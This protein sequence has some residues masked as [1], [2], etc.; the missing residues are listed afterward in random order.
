MDD[1]RLCVDVGTT[2]TRAWLTQGT[3]VLVRR[4][5]PVGARDT[6][7]DG[8]AGTLARALRDVLADVQ[9][10]SPRP[11]PAGSWLPAC[12]PL[13]RG[14]REVPHV[15]AP[16]GLAEL[17]AA[18]HEE[19]LSEVSELPFLFVPGVRTSTRPGADGI[20]GRDVMRGEETLSLGLAPLGLL[21]PG[22]GLLSLGSHWKLI[23][24]DLE[25]R[26]AFSITSIAGSCCRPS[27]SRRSSR[28]R[29]LTGRSRRQTRPRCG[30]ECARRGAT[31]SRAPSSACACWSW[32]RRR[33]RAE[34][35]A[36]ALGAFVGADFD[37]LEAALGT[38]TP[39]TIAG[40]EKTGG[41]WAQALEEAGHPVAFADGRGGGGGPAGRP[42]RDRRR[43][44]RHGMTATRPILKWAGGKQALAARLVE[45]FPADY[46][47][48]FEP[49]VGGASVFLALGPARAVLCDRNR[50][51]IE[52]YE[53]VR[54]DAPRWPRCSARCRTRAR[55]T[56][57]SARST[58]AGWGRCAAR[59]TSCTSTRPASAASSA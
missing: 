47:R 22:A 30:A 32:H 51:L 7:R 1:T 53:A 36:F 2:N 34:R 8:H 10:A 27:A 26:V 20:S 40:G 35:L 50:W 21:A 57:A 37:H 25:G 17:A 23:R 12:S 55:T 43:A 14:L 4:E 3:Q 45:R 48:Y 46:D 38:G 24:L 9:R 56:C 52:T 39:V 54:D 28:P 58:P 41:A 18:A 33:R 15:A 42:A 11:G 29:C 49:F 5:A 31:A 13:R 44:H 6:A 59:R 19:V 16:V